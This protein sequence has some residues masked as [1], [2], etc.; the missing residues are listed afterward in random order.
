MKNRWVQSCKETDIAVVMLVCDL[1]E[2]LI[3]I[4][5]FWNLILCRW[6]NTHKQFGGVYY[7]HIQGQALQAVSLCAVF[8]KERLSICSTVF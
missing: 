4:R 2:M 7:L 5:V 1:T 6:V 8:M 3:K